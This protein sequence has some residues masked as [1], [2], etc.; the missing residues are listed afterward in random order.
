MSDK[1]TVKV[2]KEYDADE[3]WSMIFGAA[4]ETWDWWLKVDFTEGGWD[5][6]GTVMLQAW[7]PDDEGYE[8]GQTC[9]G[10][11]TISDVVAAL[12]ALSGNPFV[13]RHLSNEDFDAA[14]SDCVMQQMLYG[15]V[16]WG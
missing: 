12:E 15:E 13:M 6:H 3:L 14:S 7:H 5:E 2:A 16:V 11:F 4:G 8:E 1:V 9:V 10:Y